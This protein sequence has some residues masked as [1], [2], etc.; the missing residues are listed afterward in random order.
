VDLLLTFNSPADFDRLEGMLDLSGYLGAWARARRTSV[1]K[2]RDLLDAFVMGHP[3]GQTRP[4]SPEKKNDPTQPDQVTGWVRVEIFDS[5]LKKPNRTRKL[6][7]KIW[8]NP[9]QSESNPTR[10]CHGS[11][12][13]Q[14]FLLLE[15]GE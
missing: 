9:T 10:P 15:T 13:G 12:T 3:I 2:E 8:T 6:H 7:K 11:G 14:H 4:N 1:I 5:K